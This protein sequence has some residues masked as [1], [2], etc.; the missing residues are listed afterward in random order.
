MTR[1]T[2]S[3]INSVLMIPDVEEII[4][5]LRHL[6]VG[7]YE[8]RDVKKKS[9]RTHRQNAYYWGVII[10]YLTSHTGYT[11]T[12]IHE[13]LLWKFSRTSQ[14]LEALDLV[15]DGIHRSSEMITTEFEQFCIEIRSW[16]SEELNV[17]IPLPNEVD[18]GI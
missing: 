5:V 9:P 6:P 13:A 3:K 14:H 18:C 4:K 16:A 15:I 7:R 10:P 12:E 11:A 2:F 17:F 8:I 1:A